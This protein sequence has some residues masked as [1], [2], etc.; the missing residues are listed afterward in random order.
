MAG[1]SRTS[2]KYIN[3]LKPITYTIDVKG[4]SAYYS[5]GRKDIGESKDVHLAQ[6]EAKAEAAASK[7]VYSGFVAQEVEEAAKKLNYEFSGVDKPQNS[8]SLYGLR[9][10]DFVVPLVKAVQELDSANQAKDIKIRKLEEINLSQQSQLDEL[11]QM[12]MELKNG[13]ASNSVTS[14]L[15]FLEQNTPNPVSGSTVIKY[16]ISQTAAS[17]RLTFTNTKGQLIKAITISNRGAG[18]VNLETGMLAAGAYNYTLWVDE[19]QADT[20]KLVIAK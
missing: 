12:L 4:L 13:S 15:G 8:E 19:K 20:K 7:I 5:K 18:Q 11:R 14:N 2:N 9:Y 16:Y 6:E 10:A 17:A 3:S 1:I